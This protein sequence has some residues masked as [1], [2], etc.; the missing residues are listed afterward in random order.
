M[1][2]TLN[3][4]LLPAAK[5]NL[6]SGALNSDTAHLILETNLQ[7]KPENTDI[8]MNIEEL[9]NFLFLLI[10]SVAPGEYV[11]NNKGNKLNLVA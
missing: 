8:M 7:T 2:V 3:T 10:G 1:D 11:Q 6:N 9:Q 4:S 5:P